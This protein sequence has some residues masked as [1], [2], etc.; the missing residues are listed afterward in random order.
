MLFVFFLW[1]DPLVKYS[2]RRHN[3]GTQPAWNPSF[4]SF[5]C[6]KY[7]HL[8]PITIKVKFDQLPLKSVRSCGKTGTSTDQ[9]NVWIQLLSLL[10]FTFLQT[11]NNQVL[12]SLERSILNALCEIEF[13]SCKQFFPEHNFVLVWQFKHCFVSMLI[14]MSILIPTF[15]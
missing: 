14:K 11:L 2:H 13:R 12:N 4:A 8:W 7:S 9:L 3:C 6:S 15:Q 1:D 5:V 10:R